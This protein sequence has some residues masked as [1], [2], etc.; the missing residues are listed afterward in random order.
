MPKKAKNEKEKTMRC[1]YLISDELH[2][3]KQLGK[4]GSD[5]AKELCND[6]YLFCHHFLEL[7]HQKQ[8][9]KMFAEQKEL[10]FV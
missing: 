10:L 5:H 9:Q 1:P 7:C 4:D 6:Q 8:K 2:C 3:D